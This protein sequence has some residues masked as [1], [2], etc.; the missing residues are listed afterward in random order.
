MTTR[1]FQDSLLSMQDRLLSF[2]FSLT[3]NK[4]D[5]EDLL[6][7]TTLK[8]LRNKDKFVDDINFKG[9]IFTIMR[10]IFIN[11]YRRT[12]NRRTFVDQTEDSFLLNLP[13]ETEHSSPEG[14]F[15]NKE[16][17][18]TIESFS[19]EY[20]VPFTMH[21]QGYKY[22]EI[23]DKMQLPIGTVKSRIFFARRKLMSKL[24][25]YAT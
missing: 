11:N 19:N 4:E 12:V 5:A 7:E 18:E 3:A 16:I 22:Q 17:L 20:K 21:V 9:W 6:Q 1:Q 25:D 10:N 15:I 24:K 14:N 13:P 23:A 2:A 8:A